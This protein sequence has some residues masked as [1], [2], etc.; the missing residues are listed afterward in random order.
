[1]FW[2]P[3]EALGFQPLK[4]ID[5]CDIPAHQPSKQMRLWKQKKLYIV[6]NQEWCAGK[7]INDAKIFDGKSSCQ[8]KIG[9]NFGSFKSYRAYELFIF[10]L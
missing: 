8:P 3:F 10:R 9:S 1:M 5:L 2:R 7:N 4:R 6:I